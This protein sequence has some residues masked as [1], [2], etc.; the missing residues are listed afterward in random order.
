MGHFLKRTDLHMMV[1]AFLTVIIIMFI[2]AATHGEEA[3]NSPTLLDPS[4]Q[5][6][7][8]YLD[9]LVQLNDK[10][11]GL[12]AL[13]LI[14]IGCIAI[15][16]IVKGIP[17]VKNESIDTVQFCFATI[18]YPILGVITT[19]FKAAWYITMAI[20]FKNAI[21]GMIGSAVAKVAYK[22]ILKPL[23]KRLGWSSETEIIAKGKTSEGSTIIVVEKP[24]PTPAQPKGDNK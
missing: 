23:E 14:I 5:Q 11:L 1:L 21:L 22:R 13:P 15:G 12:P 2:V 4:A 20:V 7:A 6:A 16:Y 19:N 3:T 9:K 17:F 10:L 18:G 24:A 8:N